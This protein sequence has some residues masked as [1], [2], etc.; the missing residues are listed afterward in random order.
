MP[1]VPTRGL[2]EAGQ[3]LA[4]VSARAAK[5]ETEAEF[6]KER[7]SDLREQLAAAAS[8]ETPAAEPTPETKATTETGVER[9][10]S[11]RRFPRAFWTCAGAVG[12]W[13][14]AARERRPRFPYSAQTGVAIV[15]PGGTGTP[16]RAISARFAPFPPRSSRIS[17]VPSTR[18][19]PK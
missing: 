11:P 19:V 3:Q 1:G 12:I 4:E 5:A 14:L 13:A 15:K 17:A 10:G 6:L 7:V 16:M 9:S 8:V 18:P 2:H